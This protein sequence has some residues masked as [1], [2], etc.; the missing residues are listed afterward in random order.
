VIRDAH[1]QLTRPEPE[2]NLHITGPIQPARHGENLGWSWQY[3]ASRWTFAEVITELCDAEPSYVQ[4]HLD[5]WLRDV[6]HLC[7]W[8]CRVKAE[9]PA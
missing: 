5:E 1:A 6:G 9:A 8:A 4:A 3:V 7:P 2:R